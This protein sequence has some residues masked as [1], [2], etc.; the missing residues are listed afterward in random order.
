MRLTCIDRIVSH[1]K[2]V[3]KSADIARVSIFYL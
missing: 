2:E 3:M 1:W